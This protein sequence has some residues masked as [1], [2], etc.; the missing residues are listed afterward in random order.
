MKDYFILFEKFFTIFSITIFSD[1]LFRL[2]L[3]GGA[4]E[5]DLGV[6]KH[7][8][9]SILLLIYKLIYITTLILLILRWKKILHILSKDK[10]I[11]LAII[12]AATSVFWSFDPQIT[13]TRSIALVGTSLFGLYFGS[14]YSLEEQ[15]HNLSIAF[16][17]AIALSFITSILL[18]KYGIMSGIHAG[19]WRGIYIHKN[20]LGKMM[21]L[22][23][24][25]FLVRLHSNKSTILNRLGLSLSVVLLV[26]SKSSSAIGTFIVLFTIFLVLGV[27]RWKYEL[28]IPA[29]LSILLIGISG[30]FFLTEHMDTLLISAGKD[31][32]LTG[33]TE[34]WLWALSDI[35]ERPWLGY[36]YG[37]FWE[38]FSSKSALIRYAAGWHIPH[39][40]NGLLDLLLDL[41]F[42]G[43]FILILSIIRTA[44]KSFFLLR[45][46][47][48]S[49]YIWPLLFISNMILAN[50][51]ESTLM[52]RNDLFWI[53][54]LAISFSMISHP[55][56]IQAAST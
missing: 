48:S 36:G 43:L 20:I 38:D 34:L 50:T 7:T 53:I 9:Y 11:S 52:V 16:G 12:F 41:G 22:S 23:S 1:G 4:N 46:T 29:L 10:I 31:P 5:G 56:T 26:L 13:F 17:I 33:R 6:I 2:V 30:L 54:F 44:I 15:L 55:K 25:I 19:S 47:T 42:L 51:T 32:T 24:S 40:H 14:R 3:S 39:A 28:M 35:W 18:P 27:F 37:A 45:N 21:A 49:I 8:D